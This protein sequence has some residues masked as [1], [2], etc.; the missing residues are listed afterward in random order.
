LNYVSKGLGAL[1]E[2]SAQIRSDL[3]G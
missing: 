2:A 3:G 1:A